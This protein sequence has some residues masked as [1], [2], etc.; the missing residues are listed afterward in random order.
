MGI[1]VRNRR[2]QLA[3]GR[4]K[5]IAALSSRFSEAAAVRE[6]C[7]M[8]RSV[9]LQNAMIESDSAEIIHLSSTQIVPPWEIVVFIED[10]KTNVLGK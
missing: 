5:S 10:I 2:G 3:D 4:A 7:M 6:A 9:Q 1:I 8:A